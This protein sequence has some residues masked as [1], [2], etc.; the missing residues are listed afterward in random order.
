MKQSRLPRCA[1][2]VST[3]HARRVIRRVPSALRT[4]TFA[5]KK[6]K[7]VRH[8]FLAISHTHALN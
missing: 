8:L 2:F 4:Q 6:I 1:T 7:N 5:H 3:Y